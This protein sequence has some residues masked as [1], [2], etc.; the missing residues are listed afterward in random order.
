[1]SEEQVA[2]ILDPA[3]LDGLDDA[4]TSE[5][6]AL[7]AECEDTEEGI[8][9][10]RRL[11]QGRLDILRAELLRRDEAG[12]GHA[13]TLLGDLTT[14]LTHDQHGTLDPTQARA[15]RLRV[16]PSAE[17][18]ER[19]LDRIVDQSQLADLEQLTVDDLAMIIDR[20]S[21]HE[22]E[23]SALRRQLFDRIDTLRAEL[24]RRYKDGRADVSQIL[25]DGEQ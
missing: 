5:V 13:R 24:A 1:V 7:R 9:Y 3:Y 15:T 21:Q 11:L 16:P 10:A 2:R 18:H 8:S 19:D 14:I 25:V 22:R 20:L 23:L 6:R 4:S 12:D 17:Q